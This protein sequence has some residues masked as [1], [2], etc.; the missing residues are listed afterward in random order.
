MRRRR[1]PGSASIGAGCDQAHRAGRQHDAAEAFRPAGRVATS[2]EVE[3]RL[4]EV[5][6]GDARARSPRHRRRPAL[7]EPVGRVEPAGVRCRRGARRARARC[8]GARRWRA[9]LS[10]AP[11]R[12]AA[13]WSMASETA[14]WSATSMNRSC[15][16]AIS[17]MR[18]KRAGAARRLLDQRGRAAAVDR[19]RGG[20]APSPTMARA[21]RRSRGAQARRRRGRRSSS[22][23]E[24]LV[25]V[26]H[27]RPA[28][29]SAAARAAKPAVAV[30]V[31]CCVGCGLA[32]T[33]RASS[34][35]GTARTAGGADAGN[36]R[37]PACRSAAAPRPCRRPSAISAAMRF[38]V[39]GWVEKR[40]SMRSPDSGLTMKRCAVAGLRSAATLGM[41]ARRRRR[42]WRAPRRAPPGGR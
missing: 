16:A 6:L 41:R 29:R 25:A 24:R 27:R 35:P 1:K 31:A 36:A 3:R 21:R 14:A 5:G 26:E 17:R 23:V 28:G 13:I 39:A 30:S 12:S 4:D 8:G 18:M 33:G 11:S 34:A 42:S 22:G 38:S 7:P 9:P 40:L 32:L 2:R 37:R 20:G 10:G 15:A 19:R